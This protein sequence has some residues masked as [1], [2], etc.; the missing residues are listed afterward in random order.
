M[1]FEGSLLKRF[2]FS[3][4]TRVISPWVV[5]LSFRVRDLH[6]VTRRFQN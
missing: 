1:L 5:T 3:P 2:N 6:A 4:S